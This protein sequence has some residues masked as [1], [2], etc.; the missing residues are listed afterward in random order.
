MGIVAVFCP[1]SA[2]PPC[3]RADIARVGR[4]RTQDTILDTGRVLSLG[5][6]DALYQQITIDAAQAISENGKAFFEAEGLQVYKAR[7]IQRAVAVLICSQVIRSLVKLHLFIDFSQQ[8]L[9]SHLSFERGDE[10]SLLHA[11]QCSGDGS[12]CISPQAIGNQP[13]ACDSLVQVAT[14]CT[15]KGNGHYSPSKPLGVGICG[16][17]KTAGVTDVIRND[18]FPFPLLS[19]T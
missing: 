3:Q 4:V 12:G 1:A 9:R 19:V 11:R 17:D 6:P 10:K 5:H 14:Q 18:V 15:V 2:A 13:L 7:W 8:E 16:Y